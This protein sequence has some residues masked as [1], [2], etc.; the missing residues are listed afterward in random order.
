MLAYRLQLLQLEDVQPEHEPAVPSI[1]LDS[2]LLSFEN[3]AN[4][5]RA[6]L[7]MCWH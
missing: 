7:A 5:E 2:P 6:R 3:E 4:R 1:G